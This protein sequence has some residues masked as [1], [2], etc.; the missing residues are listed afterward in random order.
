MGNAVDPDDDAE[1]MEDPA[2]IFCIRNGSIFFHSKQEL[3]TIVAGADAQDIR[4]VP[5][6]NFFYRSHQ[7]V[8]MV[9]LLSVGAEL[10]LQSRSLVVSRQYLRVCCV[11][12]TGFLLFKER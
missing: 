3:E 7:H 11:A 4:S 10:R 12:V 1:H 9:T 2:F 6:R 5:V 8:P